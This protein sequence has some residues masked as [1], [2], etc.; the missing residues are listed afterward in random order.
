MSEGREI[1]PRTFIRHKE[2]IQEV[3]GINI[4]CDRKNGNVYYIDDSEEIER[5]GVRSWLLN[6]LT[7]SNLINESHKLKSRILFENIPSGQRFLTLI[8]EAMRDSSEIEITYQ[9]FYSNTSEIFEAEPYCLK[10][11]KQR[12]YVLVHIPKRNAVRTYA[13]DRIQHLR[14]T[15]KKFKL[16]ENFNGDAFFENNFGIIINK[17]IPPCRV[18]IKVFDDQQK[19][20]ETLPLHN[21]QKKIKTSEDYSVFS[22]YISPTFDFKKEILSY[23][24]NVEVLSP[25][26]FRKEIADHIKDMNKLYSKN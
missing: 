9:K 26:W 14:I 23:G 25:A 7:V 21:S 4:E 22:Y 17:N 11:F 10:I 15:G 24:S 8:I 19:Y 2:A 5:Q 12:W 16:P 13:L 3:F 1:P 6:T 20:F 18:E